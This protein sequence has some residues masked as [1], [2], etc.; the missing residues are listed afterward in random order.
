MKTRRPSSTGSV[1]RAIPGVLIAVMIALATPL[2]AQSFDVGSNGSLGDVVITNNTTLDLPN[3]GKLHFRSL[4][5]NGGVTLSFNRN[6]RNTPVFVLA[7]SNV[8]VNGT[9]NVDGGGRSANTGGLGGPGGFDGGKPGFGTESP[10]GFGY[11]PGGGSSGI[12]SCQQV[13]ISAQGGSYST[14]GFSASSGIYGS[15]LLIPLVGGS[16]GGGGPG[17]LS[18][19]GGGGGA[20][21]IAAN[22]RVSVNGAVLARGGFGGTC[23]NAGSGGAIRLVSFTVDGAGTLNT[24]NGNTPSRGFGGGGFGRV[25]IDTIVRTGVNFSISG[26]SSIG[27][28]L[29]VFPPTVPTLTVTEAAGNTV[30][31]GS[32]PVTFVLPF[33]SS[34]NQTITIQANGFARSVPILIT[35]TPD[36]GERRTFTNEVD[37][38]SVNPAFRTVPV[39][40]PVNTLVTVHC[41]TR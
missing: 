6:P 5:V 1:P 39:T 12:N 36:S 20:V 38:V 7:Q 18:G 25:R 34:T 31:T 16:G 23:D 30:T 41:W 15:T 2:A 3:D 4:T 17:S 21:L 10:A 28:N 40:V 27:G 32:G 29:L 9:I 33:G 8:V 22:I 19:G 26:V 37:N 14:L 11:G 24:D 13:G 35:L